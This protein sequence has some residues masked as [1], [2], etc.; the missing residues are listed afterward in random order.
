MKGSALEDGAAQ[1]ITA[2]NELGSQSIS[3]LSGV[4]TCHLSR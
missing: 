2:R 4:F 3:F 1:D